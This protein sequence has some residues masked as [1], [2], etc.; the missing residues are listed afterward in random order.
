MWYF[1]WNRSGMY[2]IGYATSTDGIRWTKYSANPVMGGGPQGTWDDAGAA[3]PIV[4]LKDNVFKM[5]YSGAHMPYIRTGYATSKNATSVVEDDYGSPARYSLS[6]NYPNPFNPVTTIRF[7][8]WARSR[9][10]LDVYDVLGRRVAS[11]VNSIEEPGSKS[12]RFDGNSLASGTYI[13]RLQVDG[14][15][16]SRKLLLIR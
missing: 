8:L 4:M 16:M 15:T 9:V 2:R 11:L 5:W 10:I 13:Y 14:M 6:Q 12:V 7:E 1:A 3:N